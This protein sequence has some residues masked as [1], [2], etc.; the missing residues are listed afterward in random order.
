MVAAVIAV[1]ILV[2]LLHHG[3]SAGPR[4]IVPQSLLSSQVHLAAATRLTLQGAVSGAAVASAS[5]IVPSPDRKVSGSG[6]TAHQQKL[7]YWDPTVDA[8]L[9]RHFGATQRQVNAAKSSLF[10]A[11][12]DVNNANAALARA[13]ADTPDQLLSPALGSFVPVYRRFVNA[14]RNMLA[15]EFRYQGETSF[16]AG[17]GAGVVAAYAKARAAFT[18]GMTQAQFATKSAQIV[19][20]QWNALAREAA[21][22]D[23]LATAVVSAVTK[24]KAAEQAVTSLATDDD[25]VGKLVQRLCEAR[26]AGF[27]SLQWIKGLQ[28]PKEYA[29]AY[30]SRLK[31]VEQHGCSS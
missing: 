3:S 29:A 15:A 19:Q 12:R 11:V 20:P 14:T 16:L 26:P 9:V 27:F 1:G 31:A 23:R 24:W 17:T 21:V 18:S 6:L 10:A 22:H 5:A 7:G 4:V 8:V 30:Q 28:V 2:N 25:G 13:E